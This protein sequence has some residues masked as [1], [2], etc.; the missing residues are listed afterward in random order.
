[1]KD[2]RKTKAQLI[3]ELEEMRRHVSK[4]E[5]IK[6]EGKEQL[7]S[8][9]LYKNIFELAPEGIIA[10]DLNGIITS[11]NSVFYRQTGSTPEEIIGK[12]FTKVSVLQ[13]KDT[14]RFKKIFASI[15]KGKLRE[16]FEIEWKTEDGTI[17]IAEVRASLMKSGGKVNG[18]L[19]IAHNITQRKQVEEALRLSELRYRTIFESQNVLISGSL[20]DTTITFANESTSRYFGVPHAEAIGRSFKEFIH[21]DVLEFVMQ[22]FNSLSLENPSTTYEHR[23][24]G[25]DG[26]IRWREWTDN[27]LFD[28]QGQIVEVLSIGRDITERK[29]IEEELKLHRNNLERMVEERTRALQDAQEQLI[30]QEKLAFM[31]ELAGGVGHELRNPMTGISNAVYYLQIILPDADETVKEYLDLISQEVK[32]ASTIVTNLLDLGRMQPSPK[33]KTAPLQIIASILEKNLIQEN[34][35]VEIQIESELPEVYIAPSQIS[36]VL[37]NLLT[38]ASQA[39]PEG[40]EIKINAEVK[41]GRVYVSITDKGVGI[42]EENLDKIFEPLF[43]TKARGIGLGLALSKRLVE[44]NDGEIEVESEQ[45]EGSTFTIILPIEGK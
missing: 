21:P 8:D 19:I 13:P 35:N 17:G 25:K 15:I 12:H 27:A 16:P 42:S 36:Q 4:V 22:Q 10:F 29:R 5:Q 32:N 43:T 2:E 34:V 24:F 26:E 39:M 20:P 6:H 11:C 44:A 23:A 9:G 31:G 1:M 14:P 38:N 37:D 28:E 7:I 30:R 18:V 41:Q 45:G 40:G 3:A 33:I